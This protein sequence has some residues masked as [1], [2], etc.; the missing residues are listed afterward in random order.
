M[1]RNDENPRIKEKINGESRYEYRGN[2]SQ[3]IQKTFVKQSFVCKR[4]RK[5]RDVDPTATKASWN[6]WTT[7]VLHEENDQGQQR[8]NVSLR[9]QIYDEWVRV[10]SSIMKTQY[11][12]GL[13]KICVA[14][15]I[16]PCR[17][18]PL[19]ATGFDLSAGKKK[20]SAGKKTKCREKKPDLSAGNTGENCK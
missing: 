7:P 9:G 13:V 18:V 17:A 8:G 12:P 1:E 6:S 3:I 4:S 14:T 10:G 16:P 19:H 15:S 11:D 20:K 2:I 5:R